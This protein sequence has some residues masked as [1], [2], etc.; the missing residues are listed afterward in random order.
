LT[1]H[2]YQD[3]ILHTYVSLY[4]GAIG[5]E[6]ILMDD[7]NARPHTAN[8]VQKYLELEDITRM[9]WPARFSDL[10]PIEY[11]CNGLQV[12]ISA[13]HVEPRST[14]ELCASLSTSGTPSHKL[15][16]ETL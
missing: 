9:D 3:E 6:F 10:K 5:N 16:Y 8:V 1:A 2:W 14:H 4:A 7:N 13:R 12:R 15:S 11:V